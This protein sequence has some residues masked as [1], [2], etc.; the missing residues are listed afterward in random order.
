MAGVNVIDFIGVFPMNGPRA[1]Q[2]NAAIDATNCK[3]EPGSLSGVSGTTLV[4]TL[5]ASTRR[6]Y[7]IP[8]G[9]DAT[10]WSNSFWMQFTDANTDV[11]HTPV[12]N[13]QYDRFYWVS[14]T[15][16]TVQYGSKAQITSGGTTYN[17]GVAAP[18]V[19]SMS[20]SPVGGSASNITRAYVVTFISQ[21]GEESAPCQPVSVT[22]PSDASFV[23]SSIP[24]PVGGAGVVPVNLI[25]LYRTVSSSSGVSTYFKVIDL[26]TGT[27]TF[28]DSAVDTAITSNIALPSL[29]WGP[30]PAM[31]GIIAMANGFFA[32]W[33]GNTLFFSEPYRP[34]SWPVA[35]QQTVQHT[36]VGLGVFGNTLVVCTAGKPAQLTGITPGTLSVSTNNVALPCLSRQ[37]IVSTPDGVYYPSD[38]GLIL[39]GPSGVLNV[40]EKFVGRADW[41][42]IYTPKQLNAVYSGGI[43][44][45]LRLDGTGFMVRPD[46]L[47]LGLVK[48]SIGETIY[49][50]GVDD[51][52][53]RSWVLRPSGLY[54]WQNPNAT[55]VQYTW[56]SKEFVLPTPVNIGVMEVL[57]TNPTGVSPA[58]HMTVYAYQRGDDTGGG[59]NTVKVQVF[60]GDVDES[61]RAVRL[62]S[63]MRSDV[64]QFVLTANSQVHQVILASSVSEL[65]RV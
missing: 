64:W 28:S 23:L 9:P 20:V 25:R 60:D 21:Y 30:P 5:L 42:V 8:T 58:A 26:S 32:G 45:A 6:I 62:P 17:L 37:G 1:G 31:Q 48:L 7:R 16:S 35:Y 38:N 61:E 33:N 53:G 3:L 39:I 10:D 55:T 65:R 56:T 36:I 11:V 43:Y 40:T 51:W 59:G 44:N 2:D 50:A 22:G 47:T 19:G 24:Q 34:H 63:T 14:P 57:F 15:S 52:A 12:A 54:E 41:N 46:G 49:S 29:A 13:D 27:S 4:Q 18:L